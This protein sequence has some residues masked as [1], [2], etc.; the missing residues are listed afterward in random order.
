MNVA[1]P[2]RNG[3]VSHKKPRPVLRLDITAVGELYTFALRLNTCAKIAA[4]KPHGG[5]G[6]KK[7]HQLPT[8]H[9]QDGG[10]RTARVL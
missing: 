5:T 4:Q 2:S 7:I 8:R 6:V 10:A 3:A 1:L 9:T